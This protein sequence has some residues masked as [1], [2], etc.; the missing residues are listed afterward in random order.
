M[1]DRIAHGHLASIRGSANLCVVT[2]QKEQNERCLQ[3]YLQEF[4][5]CCNKDL[6]ILALCSK[7]HM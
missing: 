1:E 3:E 6:L 5:T 2:N 7:L 4:T